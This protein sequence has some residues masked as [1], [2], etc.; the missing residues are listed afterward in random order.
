[1]EAWII[2]LVEHYGYFG[3]FM[4][5]AIE[6]IFP[7]IPSE[8]ILT[9]S[10]FMTNSTTLTITG[11]VLISTA[12]SVIGAV[13]LYGIGLALDVERMGSVIDRYGKFLRLSRDDLTKADNWFQKYGIWTV[14]FC[15]LIPLIRSLISIPA[16]MS[17]MNFPLFLLLTT[18]GTL[19]WNTVLVR[20]GAAVGS[21]WQDIVAYMDVF[22]TAIYMLIAV[23]FFLVCIWYFR[24]RGNK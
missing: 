16:G 24:K 18:V 1:M 12:G 11:V 13:I 23:L 5:I 17:R 4:L 15:R 22:S 8:V 14:L 2:Q 20:L 19:I 3:I 21:N 10:G 7:P 9:F 6:N